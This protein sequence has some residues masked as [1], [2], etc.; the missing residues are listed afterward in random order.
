VSKKGVYPFKYPFKEEILMDITGLPNDLTT[1]VG[2]LLFIGMMA[3]AMLCGLL[4]GSRLSQPSRRR[5][6]REL[7]A[8]A[9]NRLVDFLETYDDEQEELGELGERLHSMPGGFGSVGDLF[10]MFQQGGNS[11]ESGP[12][13]WS[14]SETEPRSAG[15]QRG[16]LAAIPRVDTPCGR[17]GCRACYRYIVLSNDSEQYD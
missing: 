11:K 15:W 7:L 9:I 2:V 8:R 3:L 12:F 1:L 17:V 6:S 4:L 16:T 5:D 10:E 13:P 14:T